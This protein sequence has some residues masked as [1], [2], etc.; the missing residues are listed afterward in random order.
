MA[1]TRLQ[2]ANNDEIAADIAMIFQKASELV[3]SILSL[4]LLLSSL[5]K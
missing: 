1:V 2:D 4:S 3:M 5:A